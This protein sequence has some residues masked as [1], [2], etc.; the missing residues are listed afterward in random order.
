MLYTTYYSSPVGCL[1]ISGTDTHLV[2]VIYPDGKFGHGHGEASPV[3]PGVVLACMHQLDEYF[4]GERKDFDLPIQQDG[5]AFQQ[6]VW[7]QLGQIPFGRTVSYLE[8]ARR[9]GDAK[10]LRA[11]GTTNGRNKIN[12][13]VPCHRVIGSDGSLTGY[14]GGLWRKQWLIDHEGHVRIRQLALF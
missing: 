3:L 5:T 6:R 14:G 10:C 9:L 11:V 7:E 13:I 8:L 2:S 1:E 4:A 12:I